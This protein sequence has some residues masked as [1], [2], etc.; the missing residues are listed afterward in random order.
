[1]TN[2]IHPTHIHSRSSFLK[3]VGTGSLALLAPSQA[4]SAE[5]KSSGLGVDPG[6][7]AFWL[8]ATHHW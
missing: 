3:L 8:L 5:Q 4:F 6:Q 1:M 2:R 7:A